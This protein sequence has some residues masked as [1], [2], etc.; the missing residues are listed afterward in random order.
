MIHGLKYCLRF[1]SILENIAVRHLDF[2]IACGFN[3]LREKIQCNPSTLVLPKVSINLEK[4]YTCTLTSVLSKV[5]INS[6]KVSNVIL[7][8]QYCILFHS[9]LKKCSIV[10]LQYCLSFIQQEEMQY[11]LTSVLFKVSFNRKKSSIL[12]LQYCLRFHLT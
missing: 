7:Q 6:G 10:W 11:T 3:H 1:Q 8:I 5:L 12:W 9:T 4:Q 2:S